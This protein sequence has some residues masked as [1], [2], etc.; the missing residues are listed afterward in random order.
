[1]LLCVRGAVQSAAIGYGIVV[2]FAVYLND[3][4]AVAYPLGDGAP[5][6][7]LPPPSRQQ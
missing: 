6:S 2:P 3:F 4:L 1:L 7:L 5:G